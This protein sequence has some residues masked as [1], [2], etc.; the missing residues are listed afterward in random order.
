MK[1]LVTG[2]S[3]FIGSALCK[4]LA[5][6][7][8]TVTALLRNRMP[9]T[10]DVLQVICELDDTT[11]ISEALIGVDVVVHLA[12]R[13][14]RINEKLADPLAVY[15]KINCDKALS[16]AELAVSANVKR[17][18]FISSIAV[19]GVETGS[20]AI[21]EF[22]EPRPVKAYAISKFEAEMK[23]ARLLEAKMELVI[24]R[25][26]LVY[27]AHAAGNFQRLL[28]LVDLGVPM[29]FSRVTAKRSLIS[30]VNLISLLKL[31]ITHPKAANELFL[32]SDGVDLALPE[33][34]RAL[35]EGMNRRLIIFPVP[36]SLLHFGAIV[37]RKEHLFSQLCG[38]YL[39]NSSKA[40][41]LLNWTPSYDVR[42]ELSLAAKDYLNL[43]KSNI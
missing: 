15:R 12:G 11:A 43:R 9:E 33:I 10:M 25:P 39:I 24:V 17:F 5:E 20:E 42:K 34:L 8:M 13:A 21:N 23:L 3:G 2:A 16:I 14:H 40:R 35:A 37:L 28:R 6:S 19:N 30:L 26:P 27:S 36:V 7:G 4:E 22:S 32:V 1:V 41:S 38:S 29:P 18:V 31:T